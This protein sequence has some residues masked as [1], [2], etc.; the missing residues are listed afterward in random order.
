MG[1]PQVDL[2]ARVE[3][4]LEERFPSRMVPDLDRIVDLLTL[5]G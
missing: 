2:L 5:L 3:K 4:A 1:F